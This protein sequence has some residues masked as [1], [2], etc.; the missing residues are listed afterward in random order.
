MQS[1]INNKNNTIQEENEDIPDLVENFE[2]HSK[3]IDWHS[4]NLSLSLSYLFI[5]YKLIYIFILIILF[6]IYKI[7]YLYI[8]YI[9]NNIHKYLFASINS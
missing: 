7:A 6:S 1:G 5:Y 9:I 2:E 4:Y 8:I 3:K